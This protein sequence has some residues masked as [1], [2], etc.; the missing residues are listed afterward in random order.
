MTAEHMIPALKENKKPY[1]TLHEI[2]VANLSQIGSVSRW[3][4]GTD[5]A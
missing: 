2:T 1:I 5:P 4:R 3:E